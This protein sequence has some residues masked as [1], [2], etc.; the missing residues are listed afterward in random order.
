[1]KK[2]ELLWLVFPLILLVFHFSIGDKLR[3]AEAANALEANGF[4]AEL[5]HRFEK[6]AL[7]YRKALLAAHPADFPLR[8]RLEVAIARADIHTGDAPAASDL[9]ERLQGKYSTASL[10]RELKAQLQT[11]RAT[12]VYYTAY[13]LR[14]LEASP[15]RWNPKAYE[16]RSLFVS[17]LQDAQKHDSSEVQERCR[18]SLEAATRLIHYRDSE[19]AG[20]PHPPIAQVTLERNAPARRVDPLEET[21]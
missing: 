14:L 13:A 19:I 18:R 6:A 9:L 7:L 17:L 8:A 16:A 4:V 11:V 20:R 3:H 2:S 21:P 10:P 5:K 1:M 15:E 12:A